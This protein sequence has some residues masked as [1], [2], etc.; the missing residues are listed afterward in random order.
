MQAPKEIA[1]VLA[2]NPQF[3][4]FST[5]VVE[6]GLTDTLNS[7][8]PHTVFA[9]TDDAFKAIPEKKFAELKAD[10]E[11]LKSVLSFHVAS[12]SLNAAALNPGKHKTLNGADLVIQKAG[13]LI[14]VN[15]EAIVIA[16][17]IVA[18]NGV[19]QGVDRVL[20]PPAPKK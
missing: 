19:I 7:P 3:S 11:K 9:P 15:E 12:G 10:K 4:I 13:D 20:T 5:L 1:S 17:D 8:G 2:T 14:T 16:P 6:A 18:S